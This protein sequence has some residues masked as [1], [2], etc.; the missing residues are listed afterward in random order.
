MV[1]VVKEDIHRLEEKYIQREG[2][3]VTVRTHIHIN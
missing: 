2:E 3:R 1:M